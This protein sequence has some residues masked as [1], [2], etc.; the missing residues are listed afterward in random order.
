MEIRRFDLFLSAKHRVPL[1]TWP[2]HATSATSVLNKKRTWT[3]NRKPSASHSALN[4]FERSIPHGLCHFGLS[5]TFDTHLHVLLPHPSAPS[6]RT[7]LFHPRGFKPPPSPPFKKPPW[8][9]TC[10][11]GRARGSSLLHRPHLFVSLRVLR[12]PKSPSLRTTSG[13]GASVRA[14]PDACRGC[15]AAPR[16]GASECPRV[17][18]GGAKGAIVWLF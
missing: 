17:A 4:T 7:H 14:L 12:S 11:P 3:F 10:N 5:R 13:R 16:D 1:D 9:L 15:S 6:K 2:S 8:S 18:I